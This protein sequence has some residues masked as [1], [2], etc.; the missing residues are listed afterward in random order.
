MNWRQGLISQNVRGWTARTEISTTADLGLVAEVQPIPTDIRMRALRLLFQM[1]RFVGLLFTGI[2][3]IHLFPRFT[4]RAV[5]NAWSRPALTLLV[6]LGVFVLLPVAALLSL[7]TVVLAPVAF[8]TIGLWVFGLFAGA[9]PSLAA[10]GRRVTGKGLLGSF[11]VAAFAWRLLRLIPIA[12][13]LIYLLFVIWGMGAWTLSMWQ[14]WRA[15][16]RNLESEHVSHPS[17]LSE[18]GP[19]MQLLGLDVPSDS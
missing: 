14:A 15:S 9:L 1:L 17:H 8:L 10:L 19:R 3:L 2:L 11:L 12:G 13:F 16:G 6:G 4:E 18:P 5:G 7:F